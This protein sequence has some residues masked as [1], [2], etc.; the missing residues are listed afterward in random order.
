M[1]EHAFEKEINRILA[2]RYRKQ[3]DALPD[4]GKRD[5]KL[6]QL[7]FYENN[8][9][10]PDDADEQ[11][12]SFRAIAAAL[13]RM[14]DE[15]P[16]EHEEETQLISGYSERKLLRKKAARVEVAAQEAIEAMKGGAA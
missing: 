7:R 10:I 5:L 8:G 4:S 6:A 1:S 14:A 9:H 13:Y 11:I 15:V 16:D 3:A 12:A 2:D